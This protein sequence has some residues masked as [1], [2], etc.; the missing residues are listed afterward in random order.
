MQLAKK[1]AHYRRRRRRSTRRW[2]GEHRLRRTEEDLLPQ[3]SSSGVGDYRGGD[4]ALE[5]VRRTIYGE[6]ESKEECES[7]VAATTSSAVLDPS[8]SNANDSVKLTWLGHSTNLVQMMDFTILTDPMFSNRASALQFVGP[9]RYTKPAL[10]VEDLPPLDVVLI[11]HDH[12]DHLDYNT[13]LDLVE[14]KN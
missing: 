5:H 8:S 12:Y 14:N 4:D 13:V 2:R 1:T 3:T 11:S 9:A 6:T 7:S 10:G